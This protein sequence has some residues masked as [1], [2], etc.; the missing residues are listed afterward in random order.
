[1]TLYRQLQQFPATLR[2]KGILV[3]TSKLAMSMN[4]ARWRATHARIARP[5]RGLYLLGDTPP[6]LAD[7]AR[8]ALAV[9][10]P[11][12]VIGFHTAAALLGF[13][14]VLS[15][16]VH[17]V[18]PAG[19]AFPQRP[20]ITVHQSVVP[21]APFVVRGLQ[22]TAPARTAI[23]LVRHLARPDALAVLDAA[24]ASNTCT[25]SELAEEVRRHRRLKGVR[26]ASTLVPLADGRA[27]CAQET[28]LRLI[29]RDARITS[30]VPQVPVLDRHG[31]TLYRLDL[32][33][34][35]LRVAAEY[36]GSS[37]LDRERLRTDRAR[38]NYLSA[39]GWRMRYFTD[40]DIYRRP[41]YVV[42][43]MRAALADALRDAHPR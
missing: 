35:R 19:Q 3:P 1:V 2:G 7:L 8:A 28:H 40:V 36:D 15:D 13:G 37:H 16:T 21:I 43:T 12:A 42:R 4:A 11:H 33:D 9:A 30:L 41:E 25:P 10:P 20:G 31:R 23:D 32:A 24:L 5:H 14:V 27:E 34:E 18:V 6:D 38:H 29:L 22:C 26:Q 17:I 39:Q